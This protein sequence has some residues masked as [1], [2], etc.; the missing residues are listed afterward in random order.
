M[1]VCLYVC[2]G[3]IISQYIKL[4]CLISTYNYVEYIII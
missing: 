2:V 1:C 3:G 4:L